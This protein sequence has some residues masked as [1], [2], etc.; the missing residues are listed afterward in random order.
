MKKIIILCSI[1]CLCGCGI[2]HNVQPV[3]QR[4]QHAPQQTAPTNSTPV[5]NPSEPPSDV[6]DVSSLTAMTP[7]TVIASFATLL[8]VTE[9]QKDQYRFI[10]PGGEQVTVDGLAV[11][12]WGVS[13]EQEEIID[14][15]FDNDWLLYDFGVLQD[16]V[17]GL[18]VKGDI[19]CKK[20]LITYEAERGF[21]E[22]VNTRRDM[23][24]MCGI[25]DKSL[26]ALYP[27]EPIDSGGCFETQSWM[28]MQSDEMKPYV[29]E[30]EAEIHANTGGPGRIFFEI[31]RDGVDEQVEYFTLAETYREPD[32]SLREEYTMSFYFDNESDTFVK[33]DPDTSTG[34]DL[35]YHDQNMRDVF[36]NKC[37]QES[38][39]RAVEDY[40]RLL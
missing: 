6:V 37:A 36:R 2:G 22:T 32:G 40:Q 4:T 35:H 17:I 27:H 23:R 19:V 13:Q 14:T 24:V 8:D 31:K 28:I 15:T 38:E 21:E 9:M 20:H 3:Q 26:H 25:S 1:V 10:T 11:Y 16:S 18:Y 5:T 39:T 30:M 34:N 33:Y 12:K 29:A 7:Q